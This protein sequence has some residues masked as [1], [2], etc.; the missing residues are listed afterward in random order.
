MKVLVINGSPRFEKS[1]SIKLA[2]AF[3]NGLNEAEKNS[4]EKINVYN[5]NIKPCQ[6]CFGCWKKTPGKCVIS[7]DMDEIYIKYFDSEL[8]IWSF[9]LYYYGMPSQVKALVDRLMPNN[10]PDIINDDGRA[11][12]PQRHNKEKQK[13]VLISTC[14]FFTVK[15]NYDALVKQYEIMFGDRFIKI[16]CPQ[17]ELFNIPQLSALTEKYLLN[18]TE[19]GKEYIKQGHFSENVLQK[20]NEPLFPAEQFIE[21]VNTFW[22]N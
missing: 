7:D 13:H 8:I 5:K 12:H 4:I 11:R 1:N 9:P 14:G 2:N 3:I 10:Y 21:M 22:K 20:I 18:V 19:A 15:Y 17:G 16:L 6:G